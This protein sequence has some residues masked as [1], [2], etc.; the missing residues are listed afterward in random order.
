MRDVSAVRYEIRYRD[1]SR[2]RNDRIFVDF[3]YSASYKLPTDKG[4]AVWRR[5]V[6]DNRLEL[7]EQDDAFK[8]VAG[9]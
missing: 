1:V 2:G 9:M 4:T 5:S 8:I 6:A 3:T 7:R